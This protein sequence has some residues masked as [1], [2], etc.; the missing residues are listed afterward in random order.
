MYPPFTKFTKPRIKQP[1][2]HRNQIP[3]KEWSTLATIPNIADINQKTI[4][5]FKYLFLFIYALIIAEII[6][7]FKLQIFLFS[8]FAKRYNYPRKRSF[9]PPLLN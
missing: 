8:Y 2:Q 3:N 6:L 4:N 1:R 5:I 7:Q 9:Y